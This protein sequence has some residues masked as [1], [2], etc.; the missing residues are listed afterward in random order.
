MLGNNPQKKEKPLMTVAFLHVMAEGQGLSEN[1]HKL[2]FYMKYKGL[3]NLLVR[4]FG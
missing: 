1:T 3:L 2:L 4:V